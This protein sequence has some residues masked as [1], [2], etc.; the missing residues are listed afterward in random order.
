MTAGDPSSWAALPL[1]L[2]V[3][4]GVSGTIEIYEQHAELK[5]AVVERS[6]AISSAT[7]GAC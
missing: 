5:I 6:R 4:E 3:P 2:L 7:S 1:T